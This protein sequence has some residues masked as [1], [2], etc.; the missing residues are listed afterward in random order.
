MFKRTKFVDIPIGH[1]FW[2]HNAVWTRTSH[3]A[4][5]RI[6]RFGACNFTIDKEDEYVFAIKGKMVENYIKGCNR[7]THPEMES[8]EK[9]QP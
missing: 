7:P 9:E 2:A 6:A 1:L 4:G 3:D 5:T 8:S